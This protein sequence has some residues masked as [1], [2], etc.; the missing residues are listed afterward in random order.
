MNSDFK[1]LLS[2]FNANKVQYLVVGAYAFMKH[3]EPRY[4]KDLDVWLRPGK[5]N[6]TRVFKALRQ[7]GAPLAGLTEDDFAFEGFYYQIGV[8]PARI[9][10]LMSIPGLKF[11][12]AWKRRVNSD[13]GGV[14]ASI[15]SKVD[16]VAAKQASGRPQDL[17]DI[18]TLNTATDK[19]FRSDKRKKR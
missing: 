19:R 6:A 15:L 8:E 1:D 10:I 17:V 3:A 14:S 16:L 4:T 9:D 12:E 7:F 13:L 11:S 18:Q 2:T 5:R